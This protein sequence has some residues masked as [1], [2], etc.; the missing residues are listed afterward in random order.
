MKTIQIVLLM[1][2][3]LSAPVGYAREHLTLDDAI[4]LALRDNHDIRVARNQ[5]RAVNNTVNLGSAGL[6]PRVDFVST[7]NYRD[8]TAS[9][10]LG[11]GSSSSTQNSAAIQATYTL[12]DGFGNIF[13]FNKLKKAGDQ[14]DLQARSA[15]E[16]VVL[17]VSAAYYDVANAREQLTIA[18]EALAISNDRLTRAKKQSQYGQANA[19]D[20]LSAEVDL[21][22]DSTTLLNAQLTLQK[23]GRNL[24]VLL[25]REL[26]TTYA[27]DTAVSYLEN[28]ERSSFHQSAV[29]NN[30][31]YLAALSALDQ[32]RLD[33][34]ST[35]AD[36]LPRLDMQLS[37]GYNQ[38]TPDWRIDYD[39]PASSFAAMLTLN[40]NIFNGFQNKIKT[41]NAK[42]DVRNQEIYEHEF[43]LDLERLVAN[44]YDA[45][46]SSLEVLALQ[47][48]NLESA[49][50]NFTR[51]QEL[52][53]LGQATTT[54]FREAQLNLIRA[55]NNI[56]T[57]KYSAKLNELQLMKLA[58]RLV[59]SAG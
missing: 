37:Y 53:K 6:L 10:A 8:E 31:D 56:S 49:K 22:T 54:T 25:N 21:N 18:E 33:L 48:R 24:N 12:F 34:K 9:D 7:M 26:A 2:L 50:M 1:I 51:T 38:T 36:F 23:A 52:Y 19:V 20:V 29:E 58:G 32:A 41:Q 17:Q 27:V 11:G 42:L 45:Y 46:T 55:R 35:Y 14:A 30:A 15:I 47:V 59:E 16:G 57:A 13:S 28:A 39:D 43:R 5:A 4:E 3:F 40:F 44:A